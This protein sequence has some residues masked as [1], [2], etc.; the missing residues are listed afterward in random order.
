MHTKIAHY[1]ALTYWKFSS[2]YI[3]LFNFECQSYQRLVHDIPNATCVAF[4][5]SAKDNRIVIGTK[6]G[7]INIIDLGKYHRLHFLFFGNL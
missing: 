5:P 4:I 1:L 6:D 3:Y 7:F 2:G